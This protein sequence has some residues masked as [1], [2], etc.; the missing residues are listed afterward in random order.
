MEMCVMMC[1]CINSLSLLNPV[2]PPKPVAAASP[3]TQSTD[4]TTAAV[5]VPVLLPVNSAPFFICF[6]IFSY[7]SST[8]RSRFALRQYQSASQP[9]WLLTL[10]AEPGMG[11]WRWSSGW[12]TEEVPSPLPCLLCIYLY[13]TS[14]A[15]RC[16]C[17][18]SLP[19]AQVDPATT[20]SSCPPRRPRQGNASHTSPFLVSAGLA[21]APPAPLTP[22]VSTK[23]VWG[24]SFAAALEALPEM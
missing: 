13:A 11:V 5:I 16:C 10:A 18:S 24:G 15:P 3:K 9:A 21:L 1:V 8:G 6:V 23:K 14:A 20:S 17:C 2:P 7:S 19:Q 12:K 22:P 4:T